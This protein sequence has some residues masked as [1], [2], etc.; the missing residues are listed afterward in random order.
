[1]SNAGDLLQEIGG[2]CKDAHEHGHLLEGRARHAARYP[3][4]LCRA[5]CRGYIKQQ[6][7]AEHHVK[8][9]LN[10]TAKDT[11]GELPEHDEHQEKNTWAWGDANDAALNPDLG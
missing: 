8:L 7:L 10:V 4:G 6:E 2:L 5:I 1:M 9:L 11:T 3:P